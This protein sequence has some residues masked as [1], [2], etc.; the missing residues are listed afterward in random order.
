MRSASG[1]SAC[2]M[3]SPA[4][5]SRACSGSPRQEKAIATRGLRSRSISSSPARICG[6]KPRC[7]DDAA[8][9]E[10]DVNDRD[11]V[12]RQHVGVGQIDGLAADLNGELRGADHGGADALAGIDQRQRAAPAQFVRQLAGEQFGDVA[13]FLLLVAE[14]VL[15]DAARERDRSRAAGAR[16]PLGQQQRFAEAVER[17]ADDIIGRHRGQ[18]PRDLLPDRRHRRAP[19]ATAQCPSRRRRAAPS[20]RC[21]SRRRLRRWR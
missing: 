8:G 4:A 7:I 5:F 10:F 2:K 14:H 19:A 6:D 11:V 15:R 3:P 13:E 17:R 16:Q 12:H 18:T 1:A 21:G 20:A 9:L